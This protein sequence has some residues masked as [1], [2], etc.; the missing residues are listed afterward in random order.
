MVFSNAS[1]KVKD[2]IS[3]SK[4][5]YID[6]IANDD[7]IYRQAVGLVGATTMGRRYIYQQLVQYLDDDD[8]YYYSSLFLLPPSLI[9]SSLSF[10]VD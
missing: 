7:V 9:I 4:G 3:N 10:F 1:E 2:R 8:D 6:R 5:L